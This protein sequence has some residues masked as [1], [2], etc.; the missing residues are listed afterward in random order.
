M[1]IEH[2]AIW[3]K[4]VERLKAFYCRYFGGQSGNMYRN[5]TKGFE[6]YF[7]SFSS[8]PRLELMNIASLVE[9]KVEGLEQIIGLAHFAISVGSKARVDELTEKVR[10]D[11]YTVSSEPRY[12]GD[13]YYE[14]CILDPDG[15]LVEIT[16]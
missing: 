1:K 9:R 10:T 4:D 14:S 16:E 12:T 6:S 8:G 3:T 13:G 15:N 7:I 11:G 5:S 2:L